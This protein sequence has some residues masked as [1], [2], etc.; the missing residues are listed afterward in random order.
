MKIAMELD[1]LRTKRR[2]IDIVEK[3]DAEVILLK[4][5]NAPAAKLYLAPRNRAS[6]RRELRWSRCCAWL[7]WEWTFVR[8]VRALRRVALTKTPTS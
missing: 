6:C 1:E 7:S 3:H 2:V 8:C 5:S 4:S